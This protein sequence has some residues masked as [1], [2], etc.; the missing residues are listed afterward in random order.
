VTV[1]P[2]AAHPY[3]AVV[4]AAEATPTETV[5]AEHVGREL[6]AAGAIVITGGRGGVMAAACRGARVI[7]GI[8]LGILPGFDRRE[9]NE[10]VTIA[11]PT[12]LGELRNGLIVRVADAL[13]AVGGA[14][15]TLS[16]IAFALNASVPVVGLGSWAI[17]GVR[18]ADSADGAVEL[19]LALARGG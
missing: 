10:W 2:P 13:I 5:L 8:T 12:G 6:A 3:V 1:E 17:D 14:Y 19:A 18:P 4:G 11:I 15:G 16:E 7:G 9:A